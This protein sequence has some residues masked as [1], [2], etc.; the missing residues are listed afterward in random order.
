MSTENFESSHLE[1]H[2]PL[3]VYYSKFF[4]FNVNQV[5]QSKKIGDFPTNLGVTDWI[6]L[7]TVGVRRID[8]LRAGYITQPE[9]GR[10]A[11]YCS[12]NQYHAHHP[13]VNTFALL[14]RYGHGLEEFGLRAGLDLDYDLSK[15]R[16]PFIDTLVD[17]YKRDLAKQKS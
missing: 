7:A 17:A 5:L 4:P 14:R 12:Q 15:S 3:I 8:L 6:I 9:M 13:K 16:H 2:I 1:R 10:I 11:R